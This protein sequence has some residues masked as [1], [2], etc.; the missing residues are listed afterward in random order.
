MRR[1]STLIHTRSEKLA[2]ITEERSGL[3]GMIRQFVLLLWAGVFTALGQST[4]A[5]ANHGYILGPEDLVTV[6]VLDLDEFSP[7]NLPPVRIDSHGRIRVPIAG[8]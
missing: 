6:R 2:G 5:N 3:L 7:Q 8:R 1:W 4:A